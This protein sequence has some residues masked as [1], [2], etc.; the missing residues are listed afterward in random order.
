MIQRL[1]QYVGLLSPPNH[2]IQQMKVQP[3][4]QMLL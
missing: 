1:Q 3:W 2:K 4:S